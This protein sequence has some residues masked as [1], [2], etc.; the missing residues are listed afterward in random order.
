VTVVWRTERGAP[1]TQGTLMFAPD[2]FFLTPRRE[3]S[4]LPS[5][6]YWIKREM[7]QFRITAMN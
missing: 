6:C 2:A 4:R 1:L 3:A 5:S 7:R